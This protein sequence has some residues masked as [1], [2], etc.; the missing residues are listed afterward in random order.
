[1]SALLIL[2]IC[3]LIIAVMC[4][5]AARWAFWETAHTYGNDRKP[6]GKFLVVVSTICALGAAGLVIGAFSA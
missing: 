5:L 2:A 4:A 6:L 1:M 3:L